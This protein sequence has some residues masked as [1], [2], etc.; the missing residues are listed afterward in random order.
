M[1]GHWPPDG[2]DHDEVAPGEADEQGAD[3]A[4]RL[5]AVSAFLATVPAPVLPPDIEARIS[6]AIAAEAAARSAA[7]ADG[8]PGRAASPGNASPAPGDRARPADRPA[9]DSPASASPAGDSPAGGGAV[10]SRT[11]GRPPRRAHVRRPG[12]VFRLSGTLAAVCLVLAGFGFLLSHSPG[13]SSSSSAAS[14]SAAGP[15]ASPASSAAGSDSGTKRISA[16]GPEAPRAAA[17]ASFTVTESGT[18]Y[19]Q[20]ALAGQVRSVLAGQAARGGTGKTSGG[21][22]SAGL[23]GCVL[24]LTDA[25]TLVDRATYQGTPAYVIASKSRVWVVGRGCTASTPQVVASVPLTGL[26]GN[27]RAL[28][29]VKREA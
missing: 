24:R 29:S 25:P 4:V 15:A 28:V 22:P 18:A 14:G 19:R 17:S 10:R 3:A 2:D 27:L 9:G 12:R 16:A 23:L 26:S 7:A 11:L 6:A 13:S 20:A 21:G 1:S 5:S 8:A